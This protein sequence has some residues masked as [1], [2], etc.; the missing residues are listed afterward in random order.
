[1]GQNGFGPEG[2]QCL[3]HALHNNTVSHAVL[4]SFSLNIFHNL[5]SILALT[6]LNIEWN[7]IADHGVQY[8]A[9]ALRIN[10]VSS[11]MS[12]FIDEVYYH[13]FIIIIIQSRH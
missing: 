7:Q 5:H 4:F 3:A 9:N 6:M 1:M 13:V 12:L 11:V 8:V 2:A 10:T